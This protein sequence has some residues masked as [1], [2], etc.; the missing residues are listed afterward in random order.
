[1]KKRKRQLDNLIDDFYK[2]YYDIAIRCMSKNMMR[3]DA[4]DIIQN[5]LFR[6]SQNYEAGKGYWINYLNSIIRTET[7][8]F[9]KERKKDIPK[10]LLVS[11]EEV[12]KDL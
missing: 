11:L 10:K 12:I 1:M 7:I 9:F 5:A 2:K 4:E 6:F 8:R 3:E